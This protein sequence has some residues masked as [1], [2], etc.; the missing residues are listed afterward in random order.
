MIGTVSW[1]PIKLAPQPHWNTATTTP[2]AAPTL[3]TL[4]AAA[5]SGTRIERNTSMS[6][7][8]ARPMTAPRNSGIRSCS[9]CETS[10]VIAVPPVMET[11]AA[12]SPTAA[13]MTSAR[14][15]LSRVDVASSCGAVVG[16]RPRMARSPFSLSTGASS[17]ATPLTL[18]STVLSS[19]TVASAV[20]GALGVDDDHE[21][22]VDAG[23]IAV[24]DQVVRLAGGR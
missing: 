8:N 13:G 4:R 20:G 11:S 6:T 3:R 22:S 24:G 9:R 10:S 18:P 14:R 19:V 12:L 5:F 2:Y 15:C 16:V 7:R 21:G 23:A 17:D 1:T